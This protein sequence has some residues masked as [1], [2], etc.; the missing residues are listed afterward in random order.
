[1]RKNISFAI[2]ATITGLAMI[3]WAKFSVV[4]SSADTRPKAGISSYVVAPGAYLPFQAIEP[5]L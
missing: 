4:A 2:A 1:M 3:S 5:I